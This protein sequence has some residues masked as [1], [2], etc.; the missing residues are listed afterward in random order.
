MVGKAIGGVGY[1]VESGRAALSRGF[2]GPLFTIET[3]EGP[4]VE[5][6]FIVGYRRTGR[7]A[8]LGVR[9]NVDALAEEKAP[10]VKP[11]LI[12]LDPKTKERRQI[13]DWVYNEETALTDLA[14][15]RASPNTSLQF[16]TERRVRLSKDT[17][18]AMNFRRFT[19]M[20]NRPRRSAM[21]LPVCARHIPQRQNKVIFITM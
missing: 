21:F 9:I 4:V 3:T 7:D 11:R 2:C 17:S 6:T 15:V 8:E 19:S 13:I 5:K 14:G 16:M 12:V 10:D 20:P 1:V 18:M